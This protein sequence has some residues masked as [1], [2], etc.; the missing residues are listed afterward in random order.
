MTF[1]TLGRAN[2]ST[3]TGRTNYRWRFTPFC[4]AREAGKDVAEAAGIAGLP[5]ETA[6][7]YEAERKQEEKARQLLDGEKS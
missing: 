5:V 2:P 7:A 3:L 4:E 6:W 1:T